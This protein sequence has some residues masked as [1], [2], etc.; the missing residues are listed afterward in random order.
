MKKIIICWALLLMIITGFSV[1]ISA[2]QLASLPKADGSGN[3]KYRGTNIEVQIP[4]TYEQ[5]DTQFRAAWIATFIGDI[6]G[7]TSVDQWKSEVAST[8]KIFKYYNLNAMIFHVRSHNN[9]YYDSDLNPICNY[10][11]KVNFANFDP[12]EYLISECHKNGIE[13]H[14]WLN[15]YRVDSNYVGGAI[16]SV[17]PV[18]DTN[19]LLSYDGKTILNPGLPN[20]HKFIVDT[21]MEIVNKYEVDA[22]H[23]DDYFYINLGENGGNIINEPDQSTFITYGS[24][25]NTNSSNSKKDWRREQVNILIKDIHSALAVYNKANNRCVQFGIAPTGIYKNGSYNG[26]IE[27]GSNTAG[28]THYSSYLF[29]DTYTWIKNGWIDYI[30]PQSYWAFEHSVAGYADVMD[31]WNKAV[32]GTKVNL[33]S[34]IGIY[35][36]DD[37]GNRFSWQ[38]N[39]N[40]FYNQVR[41]TTKL[42]NVDGVCIFSY[43]HIKEAYNNNTSKK[44][45]AQLNNVKT[46]AFTKIVLQP[47][48]KAFDNITLGSVTNFTVNGKKLSWNALPN[49]K[50]YAIYRSA[51]ELTY[52]A[53]EIYD[54]IGGT[55]STIAWTDSSAE[56]FYYYDVRPVSYSNTLGAAT[57]EMP[58][59]KPT[60]TIE[61]DT[62]ATSTLNGTEV[63]QN[64][65]L[66]NMG[67]IQIGFTRSVF[68]ASNA[69]SVSRQDYT[70]TSS[71]P[72]VATI[73]EWGTI[74]ALAEGKTTII[75]KYKQD[76]KKFGMFEI[77][78]YKEKA[79]IEQSFT[80]NFYDGDNLLKTET[81][82]FGLSATAPIVANKTVGDLTYKHTGWDKTFSAVTGDLNIN[83]VFTALPKTYEVKFVNYD[84]TVLSLQNVYEGFDATAPANPTKP[85]SG[86]YF[87]SFT[88]WDKTF[89]NVQSN[90]V[91]NAVYSAL[92]IAAPTYCTVIFVDYDDKVLKTESVLL[93][94]DATPPTAPERTGDAQY[95]YKFK[96]WDGTYKTVL[97][98]TTI[99]ATYTQTLNIYQ[100]QFLDDD[101]TLIKTVN[102]LYGES[103][104]APTNPEKAGNAE[105]TYTFT[106]WNQDYNN[107][108]ESLIVKATYESVRNKYEVT[109]I[110]S[111]N[112]VLKSEMVEYGA[113]ATAPANPTIPATPEHTYTFTG[114]DQDYSNIKESL[115]VKAIYT[116]TLV[117]FIV[118]FVD[119]NSNVLKEEIVNYGASATAPTNPTKPATPQY[120]YIFTGWDQG[121]T[122]VTSNKTIKAVYSEKVN[123]YTVKFTTEDGTVIK[124]E[125][126]EYGAS[127]TA[128]NAPEKEG[129]TFDSW[130]ESFDDV[131]KDLNIKPIYQ[132]IE[133]PIDPKDGCKKK[134]SGIIAIMFTTPLIAL[135]LRKKKD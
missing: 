134:S 88:G 36:A 64:N 125:K 124:S 131:Q 11:S 27:S 5:P 104:K 44:T 39:S 48:L 87:Y 68:L 115:T 98:D 21:C 14:A 59:P 74:N 70:W 91:V 132:E 114:W 7:Y 19:N 35:M 13:F 73:S 119:E 81:V 85:I 60:F 23:F 69:P 105:Y 41:Y 40:E 33:Y 18:N 93:G 89:T 107:V 6:A 133:A 82:K 58:I 16:P 47:E 77:V 99:K 83:A 62:S 53:S 55:T 97:A 72:S 29:C 130:S 8:I 126:V 135:V 100:V 28:Q 52:D 43:K 32:S 123:E 90:L 118:T 84:G 127:A 128:P 112:T 30:L 45:T 76:N 26:P 71:N 4:T 120:T 56:T 31:W 61:T 101:G 57:K 67:T 25:Y 122:N 116:T 92:P 86:G 12:L 129:Y 66:P 22:I 50:F 24:G 80:V 42:E 49:A 111:D 38:T 2:Y 109:F 46:K 79:P 3:V 110:N 15:P 96:S 65:G 51:N 1:N 94:G 95:S 9:A 113:S 37:T 75:G 103:A 17:N 108:K 34:G 106:G 117:T 102:V 78:V 20:V 121:F 63:T 54:I 10:W